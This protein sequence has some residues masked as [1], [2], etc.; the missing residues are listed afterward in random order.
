MTENKDLDIMR[1][2]IE[3]K[4]QKSAS[5]GSIKRGPED[6]HS[7]RKTGNRK[8]GKESLVSEK[9]GEPGDEI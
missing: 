2:I 7:T 4:R 9:T 1:R 6:L 5:Q 3:K 8:R